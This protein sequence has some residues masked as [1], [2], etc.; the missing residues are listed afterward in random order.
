MASSL[1][2]KDV[3]SL[4]DLTTAQVYEVLDTAA[5]FK[6]DPQACIDAAPLK[7]KAIAIIMQK[8]S[9]RTRVSFEVATT[10]LGAHPVVMTGTDSAFSRG[11]T[12]YDTARVLSRF[13]DAI[14]L[15][16]FS[17][18]F[19]KDVADAADVPVVNA[20]TDWHHPCQG[21]ADLLTIREKFG[22]FEGLKFVYS[23]DGANNMA[24][25]YLLA[26]ALVGM[27]I[28]IATPLTA[29]PNT[30]V[31]C[32]AR[33]IAQETGAKISL[34]Y[35]ARDALKG[36]DIVMTDT[37]TSMGQEDEHDERL[38]TFL[39]F[40]INAENFAL[41]SERAIFMHCLPAHRGE[42]VTPEVIDSERSVIFDQAENR[43]HAQQA[44]LY[45]L[46]HEGN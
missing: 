20:L 40:Q 23:G 11:E 19:L 27:D 35:D 6:A 25:T 42:E 31:M 44:L 21:L 17:D 7:G 8:P 2:G 34:S 29:L 5:A 37:F 38:G 41:A 12:T 3:L 26:C 15:R 45:L 13:C 36:A 46:L 9:L 24:H 4:A 16:T 14:V 39:P 33:D 1:F 28:T 22:S 30:E 43:L 32:A 18:H 10:R